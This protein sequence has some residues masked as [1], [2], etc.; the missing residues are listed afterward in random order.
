MARPTSTDSNLTGE[1]QRTGLRYRSAQPLNASV[2]G[3]PLR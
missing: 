3:Y 2:S 1:L